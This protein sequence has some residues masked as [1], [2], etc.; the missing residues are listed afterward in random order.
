M[1][2]SIILFCVSAVFRALDQII[3]WEQW[4]VSWLPAW[5][6]FWNCRY[7]ST[8]DSFHTYMGVKLI[9]FG[10]A[11]YALPP[12]PWWIVGGIILA[13]YQV[14]NLFFHIVFKKPKYWRWPILKLQLFLRLKKLKRDA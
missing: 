2:I 1:E 13:Y 3:H 5:V 11:F 9:S 10:L 6:F 12:L 7:L 4:G 8:L 14:F